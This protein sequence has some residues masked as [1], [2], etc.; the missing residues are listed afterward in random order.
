MD[1]SG[2]VDGTDEGCLGGRQ[3]LAGRT[4]CSVSGQ[5]TTEQDTVQ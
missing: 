1:A 3:A 2:A 4:V 5:A